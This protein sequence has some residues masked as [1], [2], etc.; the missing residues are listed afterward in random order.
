MYVLTCVGVKQKEKED[1]EEIATELEL[2]LD[3]NDLVQ[4]VVPDRSDTMTLTPLPSSSSLNL[5]FAQL[6]PLLVLTFCPTNSPTDIP[7]APQVQD[8]RRILRHST[9][10][11]TI[12]ALLQHKRNR[13]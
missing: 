2:V 5:C 4:Y 12:Y 7:P 6:L 3:E 13:V 10:R 11:S 1:L 8:W 9:L